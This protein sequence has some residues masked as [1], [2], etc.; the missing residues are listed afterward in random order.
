[1]QE[2]NISGITKRIE[3]K[4]VLVA[5]SGGVDSMVLLSCLVDLREY[6]NFY[7]EVIHI[8]HNLRGTESNEDA[9]H[10]LNFCKNIN[11]PCVIKSVD[12]I[13]NKNENKQTL[14][15]SARDLRYKE[16]YNYQES[17]KFDYIVIAHN[18]DDNAE[19]V[20]MHICR[21][22]GLKGA[23]GIKENDKILRPLLEY[24]K[25]EIIK[26]AKENNIKYR[27]D[28]SNTDI[29]YVRNYIR[30][31]ILPRLEEIY[32][33]V[34]QNL[35]KFAEIASIDDEFIN[36]LIDYSVIKKQKDAIKL[37]IDAFK[38]HESIINRIIYKVLN[39]L[40]IFA[41]IEQKHL[42]MIKDLAHMKNGSYI[43]LPHELNVYR[44]YDNLVFTF[45][46]LK[47]Q[48]T[49]F[50]QYSMG[51]IVFDNVLINIVEVSSDDVE[52]G[53]GSLYFDLDSIPGTAIFRNK[54]DGDIIHK[55][56]S[57]TKNY[58]DYLTDKK[59][60]LR[61]RNN[62]IVLANENKILLTIGMDIS[63]DIKITS[64]TNRIGK[65]TTKN[66]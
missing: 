66:F 14:E 52:F 1:M 57:G 58:S 30:H 35:S 51:E 22:S 26:Y 47:T 24:S 46:K 10:V 9:K 8:N 44:E 33:N 65:L 6:V 38:N 20:L 36:N 2:I 18:S 43:C 13:K 62:V 60:P 17:N 59:V 56:N 63:D 4:R 11:V 29:K 23:S 53:D 27:E 54:K 34:K 50:K 21:G 3:N 48:N 25:A 61:N 12:V 55:L 32:P 45:K 15:Q 16:I 39:E 40:N 41:D 5:V 31:E 42:K 49:D 7:M 64:L 19:T 37:N 28:S